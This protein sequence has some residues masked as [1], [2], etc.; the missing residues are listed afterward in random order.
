MITR[1]VDIKDTS[2]AAPT[3]HL[4]EKLGHNL[5]KLYVITWQKGDAGDLSDNIEISF[6]SGNKFK[7]TFVLWVRLLRILPKVDGVFCHQ[8]PEYT[9]LTAPLAKFFRKKVITWYTHGAVSSRLKLV[10]LLADKI[11][12]ASEKSCRLKNRKKVEVTGHGIDVEKFKKRTEEKDDKEFKIISVGRISPTKNQK[13]LIEAIDILVQKGIKDF[14]VEIF[15]QTVLKKDVKY[16]ES[17]DSLIREKKLEEYVNFKQASYSEMSSIYQTSDLMINLSQTGSVDKVVLEAMACERL[18]LTS[19]EAFV[20]ILNDK[21][22]LFEPKNHQDLAN[23]IVDLMNLSKEEKEIIGQR[24]GQEVVK[25]HNLDNLV[26]KIIN[27][28]K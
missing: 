15:G 12:T 21:R 3:Y 14:K 27:Q 11:L 8:N 6:L 26:L 20:N 23:K 10:N 17:L 5:D 13:T 28:Y 7:K 19:N 25:N 2:P 22:L 24:L 9:I 4:V 18:V 16:R 1:K